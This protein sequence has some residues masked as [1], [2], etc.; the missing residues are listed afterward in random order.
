[1]AYMERFIYGLARWLRWLGCIALL[2]MMLI[3]GFN[4]VLRLFGLPIL[5]T[6]EFVGFLERAE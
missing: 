1:M 5:G 4:V 2:A 3:V 6:Y